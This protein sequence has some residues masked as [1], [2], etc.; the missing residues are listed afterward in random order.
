MESSDNRIPVLLIEDDPVHQEQIRE[1]LKDAYQV[2]TLDEY[3]TY[4]FL[5]YKAD[6]PD[7]QIV[8]VDLVFPEAKDASPAA[9]IEKLTTELWP[10]DRSAL[11]IVYSG[12][13]EECMLPSRRAVGPNCSFLEKGPTDSLGLI[14][15]A[16]LSS[17]RELVDRCRKVSSP[18][19]RKPQVDSYSYYQTIERFI[20][21]YELFDRAERF[22]PSDENPVSLPS[23]YRE[24]FENIRRST[25][26]LAK[27]TEFATN[28]AKAGEQCKFVTIGV[29]GSV[30]R[31]EMR[32]DSDIECTVYYS[33][34]EERRDPRRLFA[35]T[36]WNRITKYI[37]K[38]GREFQGSNRL[39]QKTRLYDKKFLKDGRANE[40]QPVIKISDLLPKKKDKAAFSDLMISNRHFQ[41]LTEMRPIF[42]QEFLF[43]FKKEILQQ[44][45][46]PTNDL[47]SIIGSQN[48]EDLWSVFLKLTRPKDTSSFSDLK[49]FTYR[50]LNVLAS[51]LFF[52]GKLQSK[53]TN[54]NKDGR[55]AMF[56]AEL[57]DPGIIK[58]MRFASHC[59]GPRFVGKNEEGYG[60]LKRTLGE[61]VESYADL[62]MRMP[63]NANEPK[64]LIPLLKTISERFFK[65]FELLNGF[66]SQRVRAEAA[67]WV[68]SIEEEMR[69][70]RAL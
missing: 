30:G 31:L 28:F 63:L 14:G 1:C 4:E 62:L 29:F 66:Q 41:I 61:L 42:N 18:V 64:A 69:I 22:E 46:S 35:L 24:V 54:L 21:D 12:F 48:M 2:S 25:S 16:S 36:F 59:A 68:Y 58:V 47:V 37:A 49:R 52:I 10:I 11:F 65:V 45:I 38:T 7:G 15:A 3:D 67:N 23:P 70:M 60:D 27:L 39:N 34:E 44:R 8:I 9:G 13:I 56:L 17:L 57:S 40:F 5:N 53:A 26:I 51:K 55:L 32:E 50:L 33:E 43:D 6:F 20:I 19:L